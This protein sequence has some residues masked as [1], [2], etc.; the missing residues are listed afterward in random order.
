[1]SRFK[2]TA[3]LVDTMEGEFEQDEETEGLVTLGCN[4]EEAEYVIR[5]ALN[6]AIG[7]KLESLL[8]TYVDDMLA[9]EEAQGKNG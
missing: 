8:V 7:M 1:M 9:R 4:L 2:V 3:I 6:D 5:V